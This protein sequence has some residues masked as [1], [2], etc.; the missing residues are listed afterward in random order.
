MSKAMRGPAVFAA[1]VLMI[2]SFSATSPTSDRPVPR[3]GDSVLGQGQTVLETNG[4]R[5]DVLSRRVDMDLARG[6]LKLAAIQVEE[7]GGFV[8]ERFDIYHQGL[9]VWGA[10]I[11][12][13][14]RSGQVYLVN[15]E[16]H[17]AIAVDVAPSV[18][19]DQ[20]IT[21]AGTGLAAQGYKAEGAPELMIFPAADAYHL[22]FKVIYK[23]FDSRIVSFIDAKTGGLIFQFDEIKKDEAAIGVGT[24]TFG[25][26]KKMSANYKDGTYRAEDLMRPAMI[27][28]GSC[29]NGTSTIWYV[30]DDDNTWTSDPTVVDAHTYMGWIYDYY[31]LVHNRK[32]MND[33]NRDLLIAV[34]FGNKYENA[35]FDPSSKYM[36]FG[37]GDPGVNY[38]Y[39]AALDIV[40]HEFT[41]GVTD[42]TSDLIYSNESGA[43][44]EAF[45]DIMGVSCE[46]F[47]QPEGSGYLRADWWEGEDIEKSFKPGRSLSNPASVPIWAGYNDRYPDHYTKRWILPNTANGDW[48]GVHLNSTIGSHWYYLLAHGG[49]NKTS[50]IAVTGIG[51]SKAEKIAYSAWVNYF[52]PSTTFHNARSYSH[53]AAAA[54]Y[55][56]GS[57]E[58][59]TVLAAWTAV[60]VN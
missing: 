34:H 43:L 40:A 50:G 56:A 20:A 23:T 14:S 52:T 10:Q 26:S 58:A 35:F 54:L 46:F 30:T 31:Y 44:N 60:G 33:N 3:G 42:A 55:G 12:R 47:H 38:P 24:G 48:G 6:N 49:T 11:I 53:Q 27:T 1:L 25:D 21:M 9:K 57:V 2:T 22:V 7:L 17:D 36:I 15:G 4:G 13:H 28:T 39:A 16:F 45:S 59:Q 32:S 18:T 8:H 29:Q 37:D 41:H 51:L 19:P 5:A